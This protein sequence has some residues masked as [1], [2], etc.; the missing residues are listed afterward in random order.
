M[1]IN[2]STVEQTVIFLLVALDLCHLPKEWEDNREEKMSLPHLTE[3]SQKFLVL[4][5]IQWIKQSLIQQEGIKGILETQQ[6]LLVAYTIAGNISSSHKE[7]IVA[8][9]L[10]CSTNNASSNIYNKKNNSTQ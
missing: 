8:Q 4:I 10:T 5:L 7:K 3:D 9:Y 2:V 1:N 6:C